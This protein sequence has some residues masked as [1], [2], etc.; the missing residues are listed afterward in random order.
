MTWIGHDDSIPGET[1]DAW[2]GSHT[3]GFGP[4]GKKQ[5]PFNVAADPS[6]Q[7]CPWSTMVWL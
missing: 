4:L 7:V 1:V 5:S 2:N 3:C 6:P